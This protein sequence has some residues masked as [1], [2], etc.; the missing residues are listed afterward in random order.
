MTY[1]I[2]KQFVL[3]SLGCFFV[4]ATGC[5]ANRYLMNATPDRI[6]IGPTPKAEQPAD[7]TSYL[8][9]SR[10]YI[11]V[12]FRGVP[13]MDMP[14]EH[15]V[16]GFI[17][18]GGSNCSFDDWTCLTDMM[19]QAPIVTGFR[20][21]RE[22][23]LKSTMLLGD[24]ERFRWYCARHNGKEWE[25]TLTAPPAFDQTPT[26]AINIAEPIGEGDKGSGASAEMTILP[27]PLASRGCG[28]VI[29]PA[30]IQNSSLSYYP[31]DMRSTMLTSPEMYRQFLREQ[32][33]GKVT[34]YHGG[35]WRT[36][37][38]SDK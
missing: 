27:E 23:W 1:R 29:K 12:W 31:L 18:D 26:A 6:L 19:K 11:G 5:T 20:S 28:I 10:R 34:R 38:L 24:K 13:L 21:A 30:G 17:F 32:R 4:S 9:I 37:V 15:H 22:A 25:Y 36:E 7:P 2:M 14:T 8:T 33:T 16:I 3:G 35:L